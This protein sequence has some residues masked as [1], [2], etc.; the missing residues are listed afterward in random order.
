M[1]GSTGSIGSSTV[2][3][4]AREPER[5]DVVALTGGRNV[6]L[7]AEQARALKARL[8]VT[9][10]DECYG[11]LK[12]AL[13]DT[14]TEVAAGGGAV[15]EA[16]RRPADWV[17]SGIVG[18]A[19]LRPGLAALERGATLALANKE[20][21]V[22]AGP[23]VMAAVAGGGGRLLPVDSEHSA[24][25]QA[26]G[27]ENP[28]DVERI[29]ITASGGA[30]RDWPIERL[31]TATVAEASRH[32]NWAMG[33]RIT[34]DSASM[35]NKALELIEAREYFGIDPSR[36]EV[37]VHPQSLVHAIVGHVDGGMIA[38]MGPADMRHAIGYALNWPERRNLPVERLD[39]AAVGRLEF[40]PPDEERYPALRLAREVMETRGLAGAAFNAARETALDLFIGGRIGFLDMARVVEET[41]VGISARAD[42]GGAEVTPENVLDADSLAREIARGVAGMRP[43]E[44]ND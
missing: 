41:L 7:L 19:G 8:A 6:A 2:D 30:F 17:M 27:G 23:L 3:L 5:F 4:I 33:Q 18:A 29:I 22:A 39:L 10:F 13:A 16:A 34:I 40:S 35:F 26:L 36:I 28:G 1:L 14:D 21:L 43:G 44:R 20:T 38:H 31:A 37:L 24:V 42:L 32:P 9:A 12:D 11:D 25:F 15:V